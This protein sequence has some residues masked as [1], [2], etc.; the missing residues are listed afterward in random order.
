MLTNHPRVMD[1]Q[2]GL[3]SQPRAA[4]SLF[5]S[6]MSHQGL[7][8]RFDYRLAGSSKHYYRRDCGCST[9]LRS[10]SSTRVQKNPLPNFAVLTS[11]CGSVKLTSQLP[12]LSSSLMRA[13]LRVHT[14]SLMSFSTKADSMSSMGKMYVL[15]SFPLL[16][17][18]HDT[19]T[20]FK[21]KGSETFGSGPEVSGLTTVQRITAGECYRGGLFT[22]E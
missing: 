16:Q 10:F 6:K 13:H 20:N 7:F 2:C 9:A 22:S 12:T 11:L 4:G 18:I 19:K 5:Q 17:Q 1:P 15:G 14:F 21:K 3:T 8:V